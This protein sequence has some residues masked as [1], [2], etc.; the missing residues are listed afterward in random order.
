MKL[1]L[2]ALLALTALSAC[3]HAGEITSDNGGGVY[4]V[5][6]NCPIVGIPTGT[7]DITLFNP[8]GSVVASAI[9][10]TAAISQLRS[11]CTSG[12]ADVVSTVTFTVTAL[13][14]DAGPARQVILPYFDVALRGGQTIAAKQVGAVALN[15][16]AGSQHAMTRAQASIK[17][18]RYAATL[19][20]NVRAILTRPRK[21]GDADAAIDPLADPAVKSAVANATF[22][23]LVGFQLTQDQLKYNATR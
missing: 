5:R 1:R 20:T 14:R 10:V 12:D 18:S 13:R 9:D 8:Q 4:A 11:T 17:V 23:H 16:P 2:T 7:G 22:E 21:A 3:R 6:S 15:F 19:P